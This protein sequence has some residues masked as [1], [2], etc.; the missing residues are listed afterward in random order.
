MRKA[1]RLHLYLRN[2]TVQSPGSA[3]CTGIHKFWSNVMVQGRFLL[4]KKATGPWKQFRPAL[5]ASEVS[6]F[7]RYQP[8]SLYYLL[9]PVC[10]LS[11][12]KFSTLISG[13]YN[14][15]KKLV[16]YSK[17]VGKLPTCHRWSFIKLL[18][19]ARLVPALQ[20]P[21]SSFAQQQLRN[22]GL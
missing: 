3:K 8:S 7:L 17:Y 5:E 20:W 12:S 16:M 6:V 9:Q 1:T 2:T 11:Y 22:T 18:L 15:K 4:H 21:L 13:N 14:L 10:L 19:Q